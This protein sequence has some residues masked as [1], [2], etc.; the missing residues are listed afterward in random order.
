VA[1]AMA[2]TTRADSPTAEIRSG[3]LMRRNEGEDAP[4]IIDVRSSEEFE[5]GHI[6]GAINIPHS[7]ILKRIA[8]VPAEKDDE[9]VVYCAVG[10]RARQAEAMLEKAEFKNVRLLSGHMKSWTGDHRPVVVSP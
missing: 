4:V 1:V 8:D 7:E 5:A 2:E 10:G 9:I 6:A 3:E